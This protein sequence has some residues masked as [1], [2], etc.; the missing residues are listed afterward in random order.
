V[1]SRLVLV[2]TG[3]SDLTL[4]NALWRA[5]LAYV[6][7]EILGDLSQEP[8]SSE[9]ERRATLSRPMSYLAS[10][11]DKLQL[12]NSPGFAALNEIRLIQAMV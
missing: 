10:D 8:L 5:V 3:D 2:D 7:P 12:A 6:P 9:T 11:I 1:V 4:D